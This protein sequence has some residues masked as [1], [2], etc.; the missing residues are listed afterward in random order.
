[1]PKSFVFPLRVYIEDTDFGGIVYH[2]NYLN[3]MERART[4]WLAAL[5][6]DLDYWMAQNVLFLVRHATVDYL[7]P[8]RLNAKIKVFSE[9]EKIKG[10][11][12]M[13]KHRIVH[14][15]DLETNVCEAIVHIV[16]VNSAIRPVRVPDQLRE[17]MA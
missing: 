5:N 11:S 17:V 14:E 16:C 7:A 6:M 9:V 12:I 2:S 10:S 3:F 13:Y 15:N 4:E 8:A 1:M